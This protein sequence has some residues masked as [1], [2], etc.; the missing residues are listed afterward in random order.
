MCD[1]QIKHCVVFMTKIEDKFQDLLPSEVKVLVER[2]LA[3]DIYIGENDS[4][5][6]EEWGTPIK[7]EREEAESFIQ[8]DFGNL[9]T[10]DWVAGGVWVTFQ[11]ELRFISDDD[12]N[13]LKEQSE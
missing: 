13:S 9:F 8:G 2:G 12:L 7:L 1:Q 4:K 3:D 10:T 11:D 6:V 5:L